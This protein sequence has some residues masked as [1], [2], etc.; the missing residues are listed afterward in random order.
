[1][2]G[3]LFLS[4][5]CSFVLTTPSEGGDVQISLSQRA[6]PDRRGASLLRAAGDESYF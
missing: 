6:N 4:D 1:M 2:E 5:D 3:P